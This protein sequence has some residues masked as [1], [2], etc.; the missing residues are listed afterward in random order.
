M[1]IINVIYHLPDYDSYINEPL[2]AVNWKTPEGS[3]VG[4]GGGNFA[5]LLGSEILKV[6]DEFEYEVWQPD[7]R[8]DKVYSHKFRDGLVQKRFPA[9]Y[10]K[11]FH[12][13]K[14]VQHL[15][16]PELV[17]SI[18]QNKNGNVIINLNSDPSIPLNMQIISKAT[19]FPVLITFHGVFKNP[20]LEIFKF[21]KNILA[22]ISFY[23]RYKKLI[24]NIQHIDFITYQNKQHLEYLDN[25]YS[26]PKKR[27]TMGCDFN[28]WKSR[29]K[30]E[31]KKYFGVKPK[32]K[33]FS[34]ASRFNSLKQ[35]DKIIEVFTA[36][37]KCSEHNF[38]L[39]IAGHG[40]EEYEKYLK[41]I[42]GA[43]LG[44][45]KLLFTGYLKDNE[46]LK[47][48]QASDLFISASTSEGC[49][50]SIIKALACEVPVFATNVGY[51]S[52]IMGQQSAAKIVEIKD[53]TNWKEEIEK[54]LMGEP[55]G[56]V[57]RKKAEELFHWPNIAKK[58]VNIYR[59]LSNIYSD[60]K[61]K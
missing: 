29:D 22:S 49:S 15:Q 38:K 11:T 14:I 51:T 4:I 55:I 46:L 31:A 18:F 52:E 13:L 3:I 7:L 27:L 35:I 6:T 1:K 23:L 45:D 56:L 36:L 19:N 41:N 59:L 48:Y 9:C 5:D 30:N 58:I 42:G 37:D 43:L 8:A 39:L 25:L 57:E 26:G 21:R 54:I 20:Y 17:N 2:P 44:K 50:V 28:F 32:T 61:S 40:N 47:L 34:M 33:V 16:S 60:E 53:Y 12:G 10:K 24:N